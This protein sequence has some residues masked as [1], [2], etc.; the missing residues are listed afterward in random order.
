MA[1]IQRALLSVFDK[2]GLAPFASLLAQRGV[3]LIS[4]GGTA[5]ILREQNLAVSD[6]SEPLAVDEQLVPPRAVPKLRR[7]P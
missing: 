1:K 6:L 7:G 5:K 3:E 4:T 2:T